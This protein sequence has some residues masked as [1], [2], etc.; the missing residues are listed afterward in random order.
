[1]PLLS[2]AH[3]GS[4]RGGGRDYST[5]SAVQRNFLLSL[6]AMTDGPRIK[7]QARMAL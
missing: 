6:K 4:V 2:T 3:A 1:L 5:P 7:E